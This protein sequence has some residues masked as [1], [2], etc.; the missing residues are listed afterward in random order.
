MKKEKESAQKEVERLNEETQQKDSILQQSAEDQKKLKADL[1]AAKK[2]CK[3]LEECNKDVLGSQEQAM[4]EKDK[5]V[6][7]LSVEMDKLKEEVKKLK[8]DV[9]VKTAQVTQ[10]KKQ[11]Q[12]KHPTADSDKVMVYYKVF[13]LTTA[14]IPTC[15]SNWSWQPAEVIWMRPRKSSRLS[16]TSTERWRSSTRRNFKRRKVNCSR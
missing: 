6:E 12:G 5:E 7:K 2:K 3:D 14:I 4:K 16:L 11:L 13:F 15:S 9:Q 8:E 1:S 10:Y